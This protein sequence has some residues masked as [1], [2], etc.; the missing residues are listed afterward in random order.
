M[1]DGKM[2]D[3]KKYKKNQ[4]S[5]SFNKSVL[6]DAVLPYY[7][8]SLQMKDIFIKLYLFAR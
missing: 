8:C 2:S 1:S 3:E 6:N 5:F 7:H 4:V